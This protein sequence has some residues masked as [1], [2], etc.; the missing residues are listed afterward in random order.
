MKCKHQNCGC[1][2]ELEIASEHEHILTLKFSGSV[3]HDLRHREADDLKGEERSKMQRRLFA[4]PSTPTADVYRDHLAE[5]E[6]DVFASGNRGN[7]GTSSEVLQKVRD[8]LKS[9]RTDT[10][11]ND[12]KTLADKIKSEDQ[13]R[14]KILPKSKRHCFGFIHEIGIYPHLKVILTQEALIRFYHSIVQRD[15]LYIDAT[16]KV[17]E[18]MAAYKRILLYTLSIRPPYGGITCLPVAQYVT[19]SHT[20]SSIASFLMKF[21]EI[22]RTVKNGDNAT[23]RLIVT[24]QSLAIIKACLKEF[25]SEDL[26]AF[27]DRGFR[28]ATGIASNEDLSKSI[29]H[30]CF[31]HIMVNTKKDLAP[32]LKT[33][34]LKGKK[35]LVQKFVMLFFARLVECTR[36]D[37]MEDLVHHGY[38][39]MNSKSKTR[40]MQSSLTAIERSIQEFPE[41]PSFL[42]DIIEDEDENGLGDDG[43]VTDEDVGN[44]SED[45][46][47]DGDTGR[48]AEDD[49]IEAVE[50]EEDK[51]D[52]MENEE[53]DLIVEEEEDKRD[54]MENEEES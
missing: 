31:S 32:H 23:P 13:Q 14:A 4:S 42:T 44:D 8:E 52:G 28:I 50:E 37:E 22:E 30:I 33:N 2:V 27:M 54:G 35:K 3:S 12:L 48:G 53:D 6:P 34:K 17:V 9:S 41:I 51:R 16:G 49:L 21:R 45:M 25:N 29:L 39:V 46:K 10:L 5:L 24:D 38:I 1:S 11:A 18:K 15:I 19:S 20:F 7:K 47:E 40:K 26:N 43:E 36:L